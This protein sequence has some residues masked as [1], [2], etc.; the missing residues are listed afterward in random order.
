MARLT[1]FFG[2]ILILL[3]VLTYMETGSKFPTSLIPTYFGILLA[4]LGALARTIDMKK[5]ALYMHIAVAL[6]LIGFLGTAKS[7]ADYIRMKQGMQFKYPVAVDE[8]AA[9][10]LLLLVYVIF[11]ARSF[12]EARKARV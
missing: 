9:M 7:I 11:C 2:I 6:G 5:R 8:K 3:G 12:V 10:A 4:I 1:I